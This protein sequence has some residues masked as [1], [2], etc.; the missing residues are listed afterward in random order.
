MW[1]YSDQWAAG[2][3]DGEGCVTIDRIASGGV[4]VPGPITA[5]ITQK[6]AAPLEAIKAI[7]GGSIVP[8]KTPSGCYRLR[9]RNKNAL[10]FLNRIFPYCLVKRPEIEIVFAYMNFIKESKRPRTADHWLHRNEL[11]KKL[12]Q[13]KTCG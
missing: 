5:Q 10:L 4:R 7:F 8:T 12:R 13:A 1:V 9:M 6:R 3:F 11:D 2:F